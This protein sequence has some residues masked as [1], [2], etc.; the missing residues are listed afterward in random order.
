MRE[1]QSI[2][3]GSTLGLNYTCMHDSSIA[4]V[5]P[6]GNPLFACS[7]ERLTR[8][9]QD[10][11]WPARLL[12]LV[13]WDRIENLA[14]G[15]LSLDE[16]RDLGVRMSRTDWPA[17]QKSESRELSPFS[18]PKVWAERIASL[19]RESAGYDHHHCHAASAFFPSGFDDALV[20]TMDSG[21]YQCPW[22]TA[23]YEAKGDRVE[24]VGGMHFLQYL[25]PAHLYTMVTGL[26]GLRPN[27]HEGKVTGLAARGQVSAEQ[28]ARFEE[29][30]WPL[31]ER[32]GDLLI[33]DQ[34]EDVD[35][36]PTVSVNESIRRDWRGRFSGY[37]DAQL[38]ACVQQVL[39]TQVLAIVDHAREVTGNTHKN[40]C[41]AGGVFANV[42]LNQ[43]VISRFE[44]G[45]VAPAMTDDGVAMGAA[46]LEFYDKN[47]NPSP[48][49][50]RSTMYLGPDLNEVEE[51]LSKHGLIHEKSE[52]PGRQVAT[53]LSLGNT[54][55]VA[56]GRMEF[57]PRALGHR[58]VLAPAKDPAI[59]DWLNKLL[60]RTE[61]M[62]FAPMV[63]ADRAASL[64]ESVEPAKD[65][66]RFMTVT[67][68]SRPEMAESSPAAVHIDGT[69][70]PQFIDAADDPL[71]ASVLDHYL[72]LTGLSA[73]LNTSF[74][75]HEQPIICTT[76]D[77]LVGFAQTHLDHLLL[78]DHLV[79]RAGNEEALEA[80]L[81]STVSLQ[82]ESGNLPPPLAMGR[83]I[84]RLRASSEAREQECRQLWEGSQALEAQLHAQ[85]VEAERP[86]RE[87][88]ERID[89]RERMG[90]PEDG[91]QPSRSKPAMM[92]N[93]EDPDYSLH[94][95]DPRRPGYDYAPRDRDAAP[96][97]SI[98]TPFYNAGDLFGETARTVLSQSFQ[99]WEWLIVDDGST[100]TASLAL[101]EDYQRRDDRI[102]I[103]RQDNAGPSAARNRGYAE[104]RAEFVVQ[105][106]ADDLLEP[107]AIEKWFWFLV[108]YPEY[109]FVKGFVVGFQAEEYL[110]QRGF[111][112][113]KDFFT[114]NPAQ[115][116]SIVRRSVHQAV[117][118]Y[119]EGNR[120]GF[121]DW[122]F[123]FRCADNGYWGSTIPE[124][125]DW[126]R[127][128]ESHN[129]RW[130]NWDGHKRQESFVA[131][132]ELL[133]PRLWK[134][135]IPNI[136]VEPPKAM[137][138]LLEGIPAANLLAK[139]KKRILL[140]IPWMTMG[141]SDRF[142][143]DLVAELTERD[144]EVS[145]VTTLHGENLWLHEFGRLTPDIFILENFVKDGDFA[146]FIVYLIHSRGI[147]SVLLTQSV[148]GYL[149]LPFLR[150]RC[151]DVSFV[152]YCHIEEVDWLSGG[153]PGLSAGQ[154]SLLD[155]AITSSQHLRSWQIDRGASEERTRVCFTSIRT[156][157]WKPDAEVRA[158]VRKELGIAEMA[159]VLLY[160]ARLCDQKQPKVFGE[161][162][163][164]V[165]AKGIAFQVAI[166]GDGPD[167]TWLKDFVRKHSLAGQVHFLGTVAASRMRELMAAS[168]ILLLPS[169]WEGIALSVYEAMSSGVVV[170][171]GRVGGHAEL[172]I[173]E[174]GYLVEPG[175]VEE[176]IRDYTRILVDLIP[177]ADKRKVMSKLGRQRVIDHFEMKNMGDRMVELLNEAMELH[178]SNPRPQ[179]EP[180]LGATCARLANDY[181]RLETS[182]NALWSE[183]E[184]KLGLKSTLRSRVL[185]FAYRRAAALPRGPR[186]LCAKIYRRWFRPGQ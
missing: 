175:D 131:G 125:L 96:A 53:Y 74:N 152:D 66:A 49:K 132:L 137:A 99:Q 11:R 22:Q 58:S 166:A 107:T 84:D 162:L 98:V 105:I 32:L 118:G 37:T 67:L 13:P 145:I 124:Y 33:W 5:G 75:V 77:A 17:R 158:R 60:Q 16:S 172:V 176:Q 30:A 142:T 31:V 114:A 139:R 63:R 140:V 177:D 169:K 23:V 48:T 178:R 2:P 88:L 128:R 126:Y 184:V 38:A 42:L 71:I 92:W 135:G 113:H 156:D 15:S 112:T 154:H 55:A 155:L 97:V 173:P 121:E 133:F 78:G 19:P 47:P 56:R 62:P 35:F 18:Y 81:I 4:I 157:E 138:P 70:R 150:S 159:C 26:L 185:N 34:C 68:G 90:S 174:C 28:V 109:S 41:L 14:V 12:S 29:I 100:D 82:Q 127:R 85:S 106:D 110:W 183:R 115:P 9:K 122:N 117:G 45:F 44:R 25:A 134:E 79:P 20:I 50:F 104:A 129:D 170:V 165:A 103:I 101:L 8:V 65:A 147:D 149:L 72:E 57:G 116:N 89:A 180:G 10:G 61:Y 151:P 148:F 94:P 153:Y 91:Y 179:V 39:E 120:D 144:W 136:E 86:K 141:G 181:R 119:D 7:L 168:D 163:R 102:R 186:E 59:N 143:L 164:R 171:T 161:I 83:W 36:A 54:V 64:F 6:D 1:L 93:P 21:A 123:W 80:Y 40:V 146:R 3:A 27:R 69:A 108:S 111:H 52:S 130:S 24:I 43:K 51:T 182:A 73:I 76:H 46:L 160:P 95:A 87:R 167:G